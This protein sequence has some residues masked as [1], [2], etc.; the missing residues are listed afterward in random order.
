[1]NSNYFIKLYKL[2]KSDFQEHDSTSLYRAVVRMISEQGTMADLIE[3]E[4]FYRVH[5]EDKCEYETDK[6]FKHETVPF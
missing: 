6:A 1:M 3:F 2:L 5:E 4:K